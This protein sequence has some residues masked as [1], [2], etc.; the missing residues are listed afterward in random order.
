M[1]EYG[2]MTLDAYRDSLASEEPTPGGGTAS[3]VALSQGAA[4]AVMVCNLTTSSEKW[5]D[6]WKDAE[7]CRE[8]ATP[9]LERGYE[10]AY[11]DAHSFD[12][13]MDAFRLPKNSEAEI[14]I[15]REAIRTGTLEAAKVPL[16]TARLASKLLD[17]LIPLA[18]T[19]NA[20]AVTD[21]GVAGLLTS[22]ACKGALLNVEINLLSLPDELGT[23]LRIEL[24]EIRESCH[25]SSRD[26]MQAVNS[27][28]HS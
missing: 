2:D 12:S 28:M 6:G 26:V 3:A 10:L 16:E 5:K 1:S 11:E 19:G 23:V 20:N 13:V 14:Q 21:V 18:N 8:L 25:K 15:R 27:R 7:V 9:L 17:A 4:L 24:D 22:A